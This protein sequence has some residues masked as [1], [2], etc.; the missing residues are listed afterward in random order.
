MLDNEVVMLLD[1][2]HFM[3][4]IDQEI[5]FVTTINDLLSNMSYVLQENI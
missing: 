1:N 4:Y 3:I 2:S 5:V